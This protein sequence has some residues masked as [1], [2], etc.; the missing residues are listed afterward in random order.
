MP[1][2]SHFCE[3]CIVNVPVDKWD[4]HT[5]THI[6]LEAH[7]LKSSYTPKPS[8]KPYQLYAS[9]RKSLEYPDLYVLSVVTSP[10]ENMRLFYSANHASLVELASHICDTKE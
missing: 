6:M 4:D 2:E 7:L 5:L 9:I 10:N 8:H 1:H 3:I